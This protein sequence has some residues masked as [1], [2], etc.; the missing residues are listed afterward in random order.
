M[1]RT[2]A[3]GLILLAVSALAVV[4]YPSNSVP[5]RGSLGQNE[6]VIYVTTPP[7]AGSYGASLISGNQPI[8]SDVY[9]EPCY[10]TADGTS[11]TVTV[12]RA[13]TSAVTAATWTVTGPLSYLR[14]VHPGSPASRLLWYATVTPTATNT[15]S[16]TSTSTPN[17]TQTNAPTATPT[18]HSV[19]NIFTNNIFGVISGVGG[20]VD[21]SHP[22]AQYSP[23]GTYP[24]FNGT[25]RLGTGQFKDNFQIFG[26]QI[27]FSLAEDFTIDSDNGT[28]ILKY[29]RTEQPTTAYVEGFSVENH[30]QT[31]KWFSV[32]VDVE[33]T[34]TPTPGYNDRTGAMFHNQPVNYVPTPKYADQ[35]V[36]K[37]YADG[38]RVKRS[39]VNPVTLVPAYDYELVPNSA[40]TSMFMG[41][42]SPTPVWKNWPLN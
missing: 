15:G 16:P 33:A 5:I 32:N 12:Q 7:P 28:H 10:V 2:L 29:D 27:Y 35:A 19:G 1:K 18:P 20:G 21:V 3:L 26:K 38:L 31:A 24:T 36:N 22:L 25:W 30:G 40:G 8:S 14:R 4:T 42:A 11:N 23:G 17:G 41:I 39:A 37:S 13:S 34:T 6:T 9:L